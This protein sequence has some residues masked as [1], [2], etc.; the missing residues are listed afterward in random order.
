ME[1]FSHASYFSI[2]SVLVPAPGQVW[3]HCRSRGS[4][5]I[6]PSQPISVSAS[7]ESTRWQCDKCCHNKSLSAADAP[8]FLRWEGQLK[9]KDLSEVRC[10]RHLDDFSWIHP[11]SISKCESLVLSFYTPNCFFHLFL[12]LLHW[13]KINCKNKITWR[14]Y[15][16]GIKNHEKHTDHVLPPSFL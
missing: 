1:P 5:C 8:H 6:S 7:A 10:D 3:V 11:D 13:M 16:S 12:V 15:N 14:S 2:S 4:Q 9:V